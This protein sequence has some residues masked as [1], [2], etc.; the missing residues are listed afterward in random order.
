VISQR[1]IAKSMNRFWHILPPNN[2]G[3]N[4]ISAHA[5]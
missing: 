2:P 4:S 5:L 1:V 3:C